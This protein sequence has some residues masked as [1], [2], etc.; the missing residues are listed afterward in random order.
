MTV[1]LPTLR[2]ILRNPGQP[3]RN[4]WQW[5]PG[6]YGMGNTRPLGNEEMYNTD[7]N[8]NPSKNEA[9][10]TNFN[11]FQPNSFGEDPWRGRTGSINRGDGQSYNSQGGTL[12]DNP[13]RVLK[14][15]LMPIELKDGFV[16]STYRLDIDIS[17]V[18][19]GDL[20]IG[21][22]EGMLR[23][24]AHIFQTREDGS[25]IKES[26]AREFKLPV[27]VDETSLKSYFR[28]NNVMTV[29]GKLVKKEGLREISFERPGV[30]PDA[31]DGNKT[32]N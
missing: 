32:D 23:V 12:H 27:N 10:G 13:L 11:G 19:L 31:A 20:K 2:S 1:V 17:G 18:K 3:S 21:V 7:R 30:R 22:R 29:E 28:D 15:I 24:A 4:F 16:D 5:N 9:W 8:F 25:Q 14:P 26:I 6:Q